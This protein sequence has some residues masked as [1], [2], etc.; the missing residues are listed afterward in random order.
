MRLSS[1]CLITQGL[2]SR[3]HVLRSRSAP[4]ERLVRTSLTP[5]ALL[6]CSSQIQ[7]IVARIPRERQTLFFSATWPREVKAIA[8]QFVTRATVHV[9][10]G[11]VEEKVR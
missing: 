7:R 2:R 6:S 11:A 10:V 4:L 8:S 9:F 1:H 5:S 3:L